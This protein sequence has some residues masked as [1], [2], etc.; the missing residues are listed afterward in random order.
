MEIKESEIEN[1]LEE[2]FLYNKTPYGRIGY[3][4]QAQINHNHEVSHIT[5]Y[6]SYSKAL[7]SHLWGRHLWGRTKL[8]LYLSMY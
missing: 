8:N 5:G 3:I 1:I 2:N 7:K 4:H 6:C